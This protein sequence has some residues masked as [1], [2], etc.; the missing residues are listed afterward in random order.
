MGASSSEAKVPS[1]SSAIVSSS[2]PEASI[3]PSIC[4]VWSKYIL[5][6]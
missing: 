2:I 1:G 5:G 3:P 4:A 6:V